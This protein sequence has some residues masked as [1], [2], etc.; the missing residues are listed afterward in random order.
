MAIADQSAGSATPLEAN[1][2][3]ACAGEKCEGPNGRKWLLLKELQS[4]VQEMAKELA[5]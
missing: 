2:V 3:P 5:R 4:V 1:P